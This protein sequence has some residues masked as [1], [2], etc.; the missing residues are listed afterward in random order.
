MKTVRQ[1]IVRLIEQGSGIHGQKEMSYDKGCSRQMT[2]ELCREDTEGDR[3]LKVHRE[4]E[5]PHPGH[6][7]H[8]VSLL[9]LP[10]PSLLAFCS[11]NDCVK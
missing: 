3:K 5:E 6:S 2:A 10:P 9:C 11:L 8:P 1:V 7:G 4:C